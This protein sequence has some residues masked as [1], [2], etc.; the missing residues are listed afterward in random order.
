M[1]LFFVSCFDHLLIGIIRGHTV[2][3]HDRGWRNLRSSSIDGDDR[4]TGWI[5]V[6]ASSGGLDR[7]QVSW[8]EDKSASITYQIGDNFPIW[9]ESLCRPAD[10]GPW[11]LAKWCNPNVQKNLYDLSLP[12]FARVP[13]VFV[14]MTSSMMSKNKKA[15]ELVNLVPPCIQINVK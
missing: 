14:F 12:N 7:S 5:H 6:I 1:I 3:W 9:F 4:R 10:T 11:F 13:I 8:N 15:S 2:K